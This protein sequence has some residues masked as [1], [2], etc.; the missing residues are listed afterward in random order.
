MG[1][2]IMIHPNVEENFRS[3]FFQVSSI[4]TSTGFGTDDYA[5]WPEFSQM[6]LLMLMF[7]GACAGST[8]GGLKV[9]RIII[10]F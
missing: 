6:V 8:G 5:L 9:Q 4:M 10:I 1:A 2:N 7:I 3:A